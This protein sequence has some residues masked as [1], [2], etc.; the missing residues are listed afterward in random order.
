M[1]GK[2]GEGKSWAGP[3]ERRKRGGEM[4]HGERVGPRAF[5]AFFSSS[6]SFLF[7]HLNYSNNS[8]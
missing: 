3:A 5:A 2:E 8:I 4:G 1:R 7:P 6:F